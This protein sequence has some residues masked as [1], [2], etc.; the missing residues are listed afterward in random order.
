HFSLLDSYSRNV[1]RELR[2]S[3]AKEGDPS[4]AGGS[5]WGDV[6]ASKSFV[7]LFLEDAKQRGEDLSE[8]FLRDLVL[9]FLIAGRDTT[10]QALSWTIFCLCKDPRVAAKA[11]AEVAEVCGGREPAYE[12]INRLPYVQAVLHEA[13]RLYPSVPLDFKVA[14]DDDVWPDGTHVRRGNVIVYHIYA[15][16][17]DPAIWGEDAGEFL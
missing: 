15:M 16:G 13:L 1:V 7:G 8:D 3:I 10:A 2:A 9:N 5:V 17:R 11:R 4:K 6:E 14:A 12:E